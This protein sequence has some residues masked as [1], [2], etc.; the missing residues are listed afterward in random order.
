MLKTIYK[1]TVLSFDDIVKILQ[2]L[3]K[4]EQS[5]IT[6]EQIT[7]VEVATSATL[8]RSFPLARR[9]KHDFRQPRIKNVSIVWR[10]YQ[11]TKR[12]SIICHLFQL[13][14]ILLGQNRTN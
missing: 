12:F 14:M 1:D 13:Q 8:E 2:D 4:E 10:F 3:S 9:S 6:L 7:L 5:L 11:P